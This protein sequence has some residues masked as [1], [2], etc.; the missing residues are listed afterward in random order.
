[1][2]LINCSTLQLEEFF[3]DKTPRYAILSH[4]WGHDEV[5][6]ADL[7]FGQPTTRSGYKKIEF[8]CQQALRDGLNYAWIDTCCIDKSSSAELSEAI[9]SMFTWYKDST[10]CYA[11]LADV[12]KSSLDEDFPKSRW[13]TRGWTLQELLAPHHV[14][15]YDEWWDYLGTKIGYKEWIAEITQIDTDALIDMRSPWSSGTGLDSFCVAKKMSWA[16]TRHTT[17]VEDIAYCLLGIFNIN[18]PLLYGEGERAFLRLQEEI[19]RKTADDS[20]LAW[21]LDSNMDDPLGLIPNS[22]RYS[23]GDRVHLSDFLASSPKDFKNCAGLRITMESAMA[24]TLTNTGLQIQLPLVR[25]PRVREPEVGKHFDP[26]EDYGWIGLLNCSTGSNLEFLG[27]PL[28]GAYDY[29]SSKRVSRAR[30]QTFRSSCHTV[31]LGSRVAVRS[32]VEAITITRFD[33][34]L[35]ARDSY[36]SYRQIVVNDDGLQTLGYH[37]EGCTAWTVE[38]LKPWSSIGSWD[39]RTKILTVTGH[40]DPSEIIGVYFEPSLS[41][42]GAKFTVFLRNSS[43]GYMIMVREGDAN[44]FSE[45]TMRALIE[46]EWSAYDMKKFMIYDETRQ[47]HHVEVDVQ[48]KIVYKHRLFELNVGATPNLYDVVAQWGGLGMYVGAGS[49]RD[50]GMGR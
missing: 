47:P 8:T 17:R 42:Q 11:Y 27:I 2:R 46:H 20:I 43:N 1:M 31:T 5:S 40:E 35:R 41:R 7:S 30:V 49:T 33:G 16:S 23:M 50:W 10:I 14:V 22:V 13:F 28:I 24:F 36:E 6:F 9:N 15:F 12:F 37:V 32:T 19:I 29:S 3:G 38:I 34:G 44:G 26:N 45:S 39:A 48:E 4:A 25:V 21:G 18:M